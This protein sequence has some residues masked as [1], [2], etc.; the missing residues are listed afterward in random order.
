MANYEIA[1]DDLYRICNALN[2]HAKELESDAKASRRKGHTFQ[3]IE[4][5]EQEV[6]ALRDLSRRLIDEK[7]TDDL[8]D[9]N[10]VGSRHHY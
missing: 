10:Y 7:N 5:V 2:T 8:N 6:N 4:V 9:F 3:Q 1:S